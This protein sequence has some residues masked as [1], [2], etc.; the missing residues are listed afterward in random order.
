MASGASASAV[1]DLLAPGDLGRHDQDSLRRSLIADM[2]NDLE[3]R[4]VRE[5]EVK[6]DV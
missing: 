3:S 2:S 5:A 6:Q 4:T 1:G